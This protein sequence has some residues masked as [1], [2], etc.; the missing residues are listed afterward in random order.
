M[1]KLINLPK[2]IKLKVGLFFG[3]VGDNYLGMQYQRPNS[4][5][6]FPCTIENTIHNALCEQGFVLKSNMCHL[7]RIRWS[8]ACRTDKRVHALCNGIAASL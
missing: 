8:R 2:T 3:Y 1:L 4:N 6:S 5:S 7:R